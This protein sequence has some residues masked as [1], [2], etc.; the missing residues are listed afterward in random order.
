MC[1]VGWPGTAC[2]LMLIV[3]PGDLVA[4]ETRESLCDLAP[5]LFL[6]DK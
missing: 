3:V 6:I 5:E 4:P 1:V 2:V